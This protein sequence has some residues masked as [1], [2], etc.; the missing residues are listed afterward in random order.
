MNSVVFMGT[1]N[2][3]DKEKTEGLNTKMDGWM[4]G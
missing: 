1:R 2:G 4:D 3:L